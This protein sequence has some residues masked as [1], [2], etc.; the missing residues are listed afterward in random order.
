MFACPRVT[1][2]C[3]FWLPQYITITTSTRVGKGSPG[4]ADRTH[5]MSP[6]AITCLTL[7][8]HTCYDCFMP[9]FASLTPA[10]YIIM[11]CLA[12]L[13]CSMKTLPYTIEKHKSFPLL[14]MSDIMR[15]LV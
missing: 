8:S 2:E 4:Q 1:L 11:T 6:A 9:V 13:L 5:D 7:M 3:V 12:R 14:V 10:Y 15:V